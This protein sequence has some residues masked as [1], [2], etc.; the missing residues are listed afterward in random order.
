M[1][2]LFAA[3]AI[4]GF[5][6]ALGGRIGS[7]PRPMTISHSAELEILLLS[8]SRRPSAQGPSGHS[9]TLTRVA[10]AVVMS[11]MS[12]PLRLCANALL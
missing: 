11:L 1:I 10:S 7:W 6:I 4:D 9:G 2:A 5:V 8:V 12:I 3:V